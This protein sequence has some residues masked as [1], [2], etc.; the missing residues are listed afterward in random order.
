MTGHRR[1]LGNTAPARQ[2]A[3]SP[4]IALL[5]NLAIALAAVVFLHGEAH[6]SHALGGDL[7]YSCLGNHRYLITLHFYRD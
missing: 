7:S 5:R 4:F 2:G 3:R 6:A 1:D